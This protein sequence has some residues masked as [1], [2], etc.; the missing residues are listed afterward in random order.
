MEPVAYS[1]E[2]AAK[3]SNLPP[4]FIE[5][6]ITKGELPIIKVNRRRVILKT[7]LEL[8]L[9]SYESPVLWPPGIVAYDPNRRDCNSKSAEVAAMAEKRLLRRPRVQDKVGIKRTALYEL[10]KHDQ[11][12]API[13][14]GRSSFW[15]ESEIDSW[16]ERR[17]QQARV[18]GQE[19]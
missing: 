14:I 7:T 12:P 18:P 5:D 15:V 19:G 13:K 1:I 11:F 17:I 9:K 8:W 16:I 6:A 3:V 4:R 10:I 2:D